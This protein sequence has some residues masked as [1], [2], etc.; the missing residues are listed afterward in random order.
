[1]TSSRREGRG[2]VVLGVTELGR[3]L[4]SKSVEELVQQAELYGW[5]G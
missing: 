5:V 2:E 3:R 1:M 4:L